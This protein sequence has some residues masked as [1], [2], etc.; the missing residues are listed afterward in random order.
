MYYFS[1]RMR[2]VVFN[3]TILKNFLV[4]LHE[5]QGDPL[6]NGKDLQNRSLRFAAY[7]QFIWRI[8]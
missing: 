5:T 7:K 3:K 2:I 8:F 4:D 6:E 1:T